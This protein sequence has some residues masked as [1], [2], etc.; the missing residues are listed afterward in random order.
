M[1][2]EAV[3]VRGADD[4]VAHVAVVGPCLVVGD[5]EQEVWGARGE[6]RGRRCIETTLGRERCNQDEAPGQPTGE[7][8]GRMEAARGGVLQRVLEAGD[9]KRQGCPACWNE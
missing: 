4:G 7:A 1:A 6:A 2:G 5:D 3:E 8:H 9:G